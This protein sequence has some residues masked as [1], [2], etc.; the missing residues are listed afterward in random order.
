MISSPAANMKKHH[1][2]QLALSGIFAGLGV[3]LLL[4]GALLQVLDL[5]AAAIVSLLI[6]V[7]VIELSPAYPVLIYLVTG[8]LA[9]LLLPDKLTAIVYLLITGYYPIAK[10]YLERLPQVL[11]WLAKLV[12]FLLALSATL[13]V[14]VW[15]LS[16]DL[17]FAGTKLA[18]FGAWVVTGLY[19]VGGVVFV[20]FDILLSRFATIY[21]HRLRKRFAL[22]KYLMGE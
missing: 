21:M 8:L 2:K 4:L 3:V 9:L 18:G 15:L 14:G 19:L 10:L 13:G 12:V 5:S 11:A 22:N 17:S 7:A 1:T 20:L 6:V 16:V